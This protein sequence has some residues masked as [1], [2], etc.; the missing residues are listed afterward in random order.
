MWDMERGPEGGA[1]N[2]LVLEDIVDD[3][4]ERR[5][6]QPDGQ[7]ANCDLPI[8]MREP[9]L[10][11]KCSEHSSS[12]GMPLP[13]SQCWGYLLN[14]G[15]STTCVPGFSVAS[16]PFRKRLCPVCVCDGVLINPARVRMLTDK[17]A[18]KD[19]TNPSSH[20]LWSTRN[21]AHV[22]VINQT[23]RSSGSPLV[24][25]RDQ[26][27]AVSA[28][29][30]DVPTS[31]VQ[32]GRLHLVISNNTL[33]PNTKSIPA[34]LSV[35]NISNRPGANYSD[36]VTSS[37]KSS[38]SSQASSHLE[39]SELTSRA[40]PQQ[41]ELMPTVMSITCST[42]CDARAHSDSE[43]GGGS[44]HKRGR[45]EAST[46]P[47]S[48]DPLLL[49]MSHAQ[50]LAS[51]LQQT[52]AIAESAR[53]AEDAR[54]M[55]QE[56]SMCLANL[57]RAAEPITEA[58]DL[59]QQAVDRHA[60]PP[61]VLGAEL[62]DQG[63]AG[64]SV[65]G[66]LVGGVPP[67]TAASFPPSPPVTSSSTSGVGERGRLSVLRDS[68]DAKVMDT[69]G[70]RPPLRSSYYTCDEYALL[71]VAC[72]PVVL[73]QFMQRITRTPGT[74]FFV[75]LAIAI[76]IGSCMVLFFISHRSNMRQIYAAESATLESIYATRL[77]QGAHDRGSFDGF[78][79]VLGIGP[80]TGETMAHVT[81]LEAFTYMRVFDDS[82]RLLVNPLDVA[83]GGVDWDE[84]RWSAQPCKRL[85][86][87]MVVEQAGLA[88]GQLTVRPLAAAAPNRTANL[89]AAEGRGQLAPNLLPFCI[90]MA[91]QTSQLE[92]QYMLAQSR[93]TNVVSLLALGALCFSFLLMS[94]LE[95]IRRREGI[96]G[97]RRY[98]AFYDF[99]YA[100]LCCPCAM[101]WIIR[102]EEGTA[103][104]SAR[105]W[106][107]LS[108]TGADDES[109]V[110]PIHL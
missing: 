55:S 108:P 15:E 73:A 66:S 105:R 14:G 33:A 13:M 107:L 90:V 53:E 87:D 93:V 47:S 81:P 43:L 35:A 16:G 76:A 12:L 52:I 67:P 26:H 51:Q 31:W 25:F 37:F 62:G 59:L 23:S 92:Y 42:A 95:M 56:V 97:R 2:D 57:R 34:S 58:V 74:C 22:R 98:A 17:S 77:Q 103:L 6:P 44:P 94:M 30:P 20:G 39:L 45:H 63:R 4:E 50:Q 78:L 28:D 61:E 89:T 10:A 21:G 32:S 19:F 91:Y 109:E 69:A 41:A 102:T 18:T 60:S 40:S 106:S 27:S 79:D 72:W 88:L 3:I 36:G 38:S 64:Q 7:Y 29:L 9:P 71:S 65:I 70:G 11:A 24:I 46:S 100:L 104:G 84:L 82:F 1:L 49:A 86:H 101:S 85:L 5:A 68:L 99:L 96:V 48:E 8:A 54:A 80:S 110:M 83:G 75:T